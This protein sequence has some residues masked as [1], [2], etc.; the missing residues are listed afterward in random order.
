MLPKTG[1]SF[2]L[3]PKT[4]ELTPNPPEGA[5]APAAEAVPVQV[6]AEPEP[7]PEPPAAPETD[8]APSGRGKAN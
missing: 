8:A 3:D 4:G 7:V 5:A 1:G 6:V 2:I